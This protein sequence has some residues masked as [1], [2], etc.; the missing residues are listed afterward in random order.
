MPPL[1]IANIFPENNVSGVN[2]HVRELQSHLS[3]NGI[4]TTLVTPHSWG[5]LLWYPVFG[6]RRIVTRISRTASVLWYPYFSVLFLRNALRRHLSKVDD[7]VIYAQGALEASAALRARRGRHQRVIMAGHFRVSIADEL[8]DTRDIKRDGIVF[9]AIRRVN[10]EAILQ[11]DSMM[12][13][14]QW[15]RNAV[16]SWLPEAVEVPYAVISSFVSP[17]DL[18]PGQESLGDLV[19]TGR[20]GLEKNQRFLLEVLAEAKQAGRFLTLDVFGDGPCR[21][22]LERLTRSLGLEEQVRFRGFRHDV[23]DFLPRYRA[24][25]YASQSESFCLAI[26]EAMAAGLPIVA[27]NIGPLAELY[28]DGIEGRFWPLDD[29]AQAAA[30]LLDLVDCEP[31]RL[32]AAEAARERFYR[33]FDTDVVAPRLR[34]FLLGTNSV[35][36]PLGDE[37]PPGNGGAVVKE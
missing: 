27:G 24:Y 33:D 8:A 1:V 9:R 30:T 18:S 15:A 6:P 5:R 3:A 12:F 36:P 20:L 19:T 2:T 31:A 13:Q 11:V 10:R 29:P 25:V 32:K 7:C 14:S 17:L 34:S 28:D 37:A 23:R 16:L 35:I 4:A 21:M 22:D 26:V